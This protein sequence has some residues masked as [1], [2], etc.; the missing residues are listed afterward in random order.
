MV[1]NASFLVVLTC[2]HG[3]G[4]EDLCWEIVWVEMWEESE[5]TTVLVQR[6]YFS[7]SRI[8]GTNEE[9]PRLATSAQLRVLV[10]AFLA[11]D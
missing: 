10:L 3:R 1:F 11:G 6:T 8:S 2:S 5:W 7:S 9:R 4:V